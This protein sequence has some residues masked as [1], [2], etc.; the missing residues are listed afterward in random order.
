MTRKKLKATIK[1][2]RMGAAC[3]YTCQLDA[4]AEGLAEYQ[5]IEHD[6]R[7]MADE[8]EADLVARVPA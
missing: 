4:D 3:A 5:K 7:R 6:A 8:L 1:L 2:L